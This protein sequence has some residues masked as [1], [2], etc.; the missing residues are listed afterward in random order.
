MKQ[1]LVTGY[2]DDKREDLYRSLQVKAYDVSSRLLERSFVE[3]NRSYAQAKEESRKAGISLDGLRGRMMTIYG[4]IAAVGAGDES[5]RREL[6]EQL[7]AF[8]RSLFSTLYTT[9]ALSAAEMEALGLFLLSGETEMADVRLVL[10]ALMLSQQMVFDARKFALFVDIYCQHG[11]RDVRQL[12]LI[13]LVFG[14]PMPMEEALFGKELDDCFTRLAANEDIRIDLVETQLQ[15]LLCADTKDTQQTINDEIIPVLRGSAMSIDFTTDK[16]E[17]QLLDELL[18]PDAEESAIEKIE[19]SLERMRELRDAGA[20][21]F[22]AGFS[23]TKRY[24]FFYT[25]MNWFLPFDIDHPLV[26]QLSTGGV[27][28]DAIM[29]MMDMQHFCDSDKYSFFFTFSRVIEQLPPSVVEMLKRGEVESELGDDAPLDTAYRRRLYLQDLY[30]FYT[31][32]SS[33]VDFD[34][35]FASE[36]AMVFF[37]WERVKRLFGGSNQLLVVARQLLRRNYFSSLDAVL[38]GEFDELNISYLKIKALSALKKKDYRA[39]MDWFSR[40]LSF[41]P[42]NA[43]LIRRMADTARLMKDYNVA[44]RLY[45]SYVELTKDGDGDSAEEEYIYALCCLETKDTQLATDTLYKLY[46]LHEDDTRYRQAL[47]AALLQAGKVDDARNLFAAL[48]DD[49][50]TQEGVVRRALTLWLTH[51]RKSAINGLQRYA[52]AEGLSPRE[53]SRLLFAENE[54]CSIGMCDTDL[55]VVCD[56]TFEDMS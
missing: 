3:G 52:Q 47:A 50:L 25:L 19:N 22:F 9:I 31:L 13:A 2:D 43:V 34:N 54:R 35:P 49:D 10:S 4:R 15:L 42:E 33:K 53:L 37:S 14:R 29:R 39:A 5:R 21:V 41:E 23:Q 45:L 48:A 40:A 36:G 51:D 16:S 32:Y 12:A 56:L 55:Y 44:K 7:Y 30:R 20:D 24:S 1:Y 18:H 27:K 8:R 38:E 28:K 11:D 6:F 17:E 46:Y 26:A